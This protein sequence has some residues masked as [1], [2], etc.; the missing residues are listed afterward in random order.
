MNKNEFLSAIAF[1]TGFTKKDSEKFLDAFMETVIDTLK[2]GDRIQLIGFGT[3]ETKARAQRACRDPRN[4]GQMIIPATVVP[5]FKVGKLF[6]DAIVEALVKN[7][8][9]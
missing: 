5:S 9:N 4:G 3:F 8:K 7:K 2:N 1:K 6:K